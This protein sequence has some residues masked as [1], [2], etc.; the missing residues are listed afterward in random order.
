[1]LSKNHIGLLLLGVIVLIAVVLTVQYYK[2]QKSVA[3][4]YAWKRAQ[5]RPAPSRVTKA[6]QAPL[7]TPRPQQQHSQPGIHEGTGGNHLLF[8]PANANLLQSAQS[9]ILH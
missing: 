2:K 8:I 6:S 3:T 7:E 9:G 1:M 4:Y 5:L